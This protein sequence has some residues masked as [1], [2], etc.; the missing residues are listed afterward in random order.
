MRKTVT[1]DYSVQ[2]TDDLTNSV[3]SGEEPPDTRLGEEVQTAGDLEVEGKQ[4]DK[5]E[6]QRL[7]PTVISLTNLTEDG[8]PGAAALEKFF[9][10][11]PPQAGDKRPYVGRLGSVHDSPS[12]AVLDHLAGH[13]TSD[14]INEDM[15]AHL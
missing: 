3:A 4:E 13:G 5:K 8:M 7:Q 14:E 15:D 11:T 12:V 10:G 9:L 6:A 1:I 2:H